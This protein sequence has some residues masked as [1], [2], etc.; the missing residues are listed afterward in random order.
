MCKEQ[1]LRIAP[2]NTDV[3]K[4]NDPKPNTVWIGIS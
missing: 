1:G 2:T 3:I 4:P